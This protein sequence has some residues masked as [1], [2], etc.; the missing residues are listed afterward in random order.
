[1]MGRRGSSSI[2]ANPVL[3]GAATTLVVIVAV[4]L[5]YN[6][7]N[8]LPFVPTYELK[9][10]VPSA[11]NLVKGN[12]VRVGGARVGVVS[13]ITPLQHKDSSVSALLTMKLETTIKPL[14]KDST[15]LV[16]PRS[17]LGLKFVEITLGPRKLPDGRTAPGFQD[18]DTIPLANATPTPVEIDQVFNTFDTKTRAASQVNL[19]EFGNGLAGRG[20]SLNTAIQ[21]F[22]PLLGN[23]TSVARNLAAPGTA[24]RNFFP[25]LGRTAEIVAPAAETQAALF[26]NLDTTF[27]ALAKVARP[28]IQDSITLAPPALDAAIRSFPVQDP[29]L[30]NSAAFFHELRPGVKALSFAAPTLAQALQIGTPVLVHSQALSRRLKPLFQ[31][32]KNFAL[33]PLVPL[34]VRDLTNTVNTLNPTISSLTPAQTTCNYLTLWFRNLSSLLSEGDANGTWQRFIIIA[35]PQGP[36][37]E[38]GP[39][40][41]PA[42]GPT[43]DNHL[44]SNPYPNTASPGQTKECEAANEKYLAGKT[45]IGNVPGGQGTQHDVTKVSLTK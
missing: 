45:V 16:R 12:E 29:F 15:I 34:G 23:L 35:A 18:G 17:A 41:A 36:N 8:G 11:A 42:N 43:L 14:P 28:F 13:D 7:N 25:A 5:A 39:S 24:L 38:G 37:N 1:M 21:A 2:A 10:D 44:H 3:I 20:S 22:N 31:S 4:F 27:G 19:Y 9:A 26:D 30:D 6:A 33:D 40:S 32:L